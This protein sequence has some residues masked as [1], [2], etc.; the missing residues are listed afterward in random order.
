[1]H[2]Q[3]YLKH[4]E[5]YGKTPIDINK[6]WIR[7]V[8]PLDVIGSQL[9][10][11]IKYTRNCFPVG[12]HFF[13]FIAYMSHIFRVLGQKG[14]FSHLVWSPPFYTELLLFFFFILSH[15]LRPIIWVWLK[16]TFQ[17]GSQSLH[18]D[19]KKWEPIAFLS[20]FFPIVNYSHF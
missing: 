1:M 12:F 14:L 8:V 10:S 6:P 3:S 9:T 7:L 11:M 19:T 15:L 4:I 20:I 2:L 5:F 16:H 13:Y 18:K 17:K